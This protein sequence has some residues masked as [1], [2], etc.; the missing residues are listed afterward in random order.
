MERPRFDG[1]LL[2]TVDPKPRAGSK[3]TAEFAKQHRRPCLHVSR[4]E[5]F[6]VCAEAVRRFLCEQRITVL[7]VAGPRASE[8]P[9]VGEFVG[10]LLDAAWNAGDIVG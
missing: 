1:T 5:R 2:V 3:R 8:A 10:A 7:N 4:T 9:Q 6:T